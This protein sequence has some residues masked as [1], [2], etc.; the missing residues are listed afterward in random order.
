MQDHDGLGV[1]Y[2]AHHT[3]MERPS[4]FRARF[5]SSPKARTLTY[6]SVDFRSLESPSSLKS[7]WTAPPRTELLYY[8][9]RRA[10]GRTDIRLHDHC[11]RPDAEAG[12]AASPPPRYVLTLLE[13]CCGAPEGHSQYYSRDRVLNV[14]ES[15]TTIIAVDASP[16]AAWYSG[17]SIG[18]GSGGCVHIPNI[19]AVFQGRAGSS[20]TISGLRLLVEMIAQ[21]LPRRSLGHSRFRRHP[22]HP[23]PGG[24]PGE[25]WSLP[26]IR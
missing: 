14:E 13:A 11:V 8:G 23:P 24:R 17:G 1:G 19:Y 6:F 4:D 22:Q 5:R 20:G 7:R 15:T 16:P 3:L 2:F 25:S 9:G 21:S 18:V 10:P 12:G 26:P